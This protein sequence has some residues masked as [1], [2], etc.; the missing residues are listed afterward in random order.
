MS[1]PPF[2]ASPSIPSS[3]DHTP[4][5]KRSKSPTPSTHTSPYVTR[6]SPQKDID[7]RLGD[8]AAPFRAPAI[9]V[10]PA[11]TE[12]SEEEK[13]AKKRERDRLYQAQKRSA[14]KTTVSNPIVVDASPSQHEPMGDASPDNVEGQGEASLPEGEDA[15]E[16]EEEGDEG[17]SFPKY[18]CNRG[19]PLW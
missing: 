8:P 18:A 1:S 19:K 5:S 2:P 17:R 7:A 9:I 15:F 16:D 12:L 11:S 4:S 13:K 6:Q 10:T 14:Q 3:K